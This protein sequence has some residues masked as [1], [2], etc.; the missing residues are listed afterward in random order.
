MKIKVWNLLIIG[1]LVIFC[2]CATS[3][4]SINPSSRNLSTK[5]EDENFVF[6][7]SYDI[8][9]EAGNKRYSKKE[10][11]NSI[12]LI[13]VSITN[14]TEDEIKVPENIDFYAGAYK[15]KLLEPN[16]YSHLLKQNTISY[17]L[18]LLLTP[19]QLRTGDP[20]NDPQIIPIG[21]VLGPGITLLNTLTSSSANSKIEKELIETNI[22]GKIIQPGETL[23]GLICVRSIGYEP[24]SIK[25]NK[26]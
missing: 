1:C 2:G 14:K 23:C 24:L 5:L 21:F 4:K 20:Y 16:E 7:Y 3:Y 10:T 8:L 12:K 6:K 25:L 22:L 11:K 13:A 19:L 9:E 26:S 17:L 18:Y 15:V